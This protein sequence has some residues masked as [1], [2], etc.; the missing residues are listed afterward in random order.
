M[1]TEVLLYTGGID[2]F[3]AKS[4]LEKQGNK[5]DCVYFNHQGRYCDI[6]IQRIKRL[7]FPVIINSDMKFKD[8]EKPDAHI[9][10]RNILLTIF[11]NSLGYNKIWIGGSLSD[12]V[13]DN[14]KKVF[15]EL[16]TF[17]TLMNQTP[18]SIA[19]PFWNCYKENMINWYITHFDPVIEH[20]MYNSRYNLVVNTFSCY[21]PIPIRKVRGKIRGVGIAY[22]TEECLNCPACFRKNASLSVAEILIPFGNVDIIKKYEKEFSTSIDKSPRIESTLNYIRLLKFL[23]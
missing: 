22:D 14:N 21:S 3:I 10:N 16:S 9:P 13:E 6:E 20:S 11:A 7:D 23:I 2:S 8:I 17:L 19:S 4:Y 5:F 12:R 18:I 1:N 15:D